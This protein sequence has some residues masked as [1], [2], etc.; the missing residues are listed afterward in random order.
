M[1]VVI[2]DKNYDLVHLIRI[3]MPGAEHQSMVTW[4]H[5]WYMVHEL[6]QPTP[7]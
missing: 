1:Y 3:I 4:V 2:Y 5:S 6:D 7:L